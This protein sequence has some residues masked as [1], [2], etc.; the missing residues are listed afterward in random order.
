MERVAFMIEATGER[1]RCMLNPESVVLRRRAGL[2]ARRTLAEVASSAALGSLGDDTLLNAGGGMTVLELDLLF[3]VSLAKGSSVVSDDVRRMTQPIW[4]LAEASGAASAAGRGVPT[5]RFVWGKSWNLRGVVS[6]VA[7][8][9]EQFTAAGVPHRSWLR[10]RMIRVAD[11]PVGATRAGAALSGGYGSP[12]GAADVPPAARHRAQVHQ[13]MGTA[14][15][16]GTSR[17]ERLDAIAFRYYGAP[18]YWRALAQRN[19]LDGPGGLAVGTLLEI[20]PFDEI[21][22]AR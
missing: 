6:A 7:E 5:V 19:R 22:A 2:V 9:L 18:Y 12:H 17:G 20:P 1:L 8:R 21:E 11:A 4:A 14:L 3:D 15:P 16:D 13:V 10:L